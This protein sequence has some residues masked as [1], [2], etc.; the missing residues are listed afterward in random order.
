MPLADLDQG[1]EMAAHAKFT[2]ATGIPVYFCDPHS[3]WQRGF[4]ENTNGLLRQYSPKGADLCAY[5]QAELDTVADTLNTRPRKVLVWKHQPRSSTS[6]ASGR[7]CAETDAA[8]A[9]LSGA[10]YATRLEREGSVVLSALDDAPYD[11]VIAGSK[12]SS[13]RLIGLSDRL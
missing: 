5:T 2:I 3:P 9:V 1:V 7:Q 6:C 8:R 4:N 10:G 11:L 13:S 12:L